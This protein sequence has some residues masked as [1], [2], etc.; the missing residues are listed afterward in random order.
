ML[1]VEKPNIFENGKNQE[2]V[3]CKRGKNNG[4]YD[5][6]PPTFYPLN[7]NLY[8]NPSPNPYP[9][10]YP[11]AYPNSYNNPYPNS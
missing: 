5:F 10:G 8:P 11:N 6:L 9:N 2:E 4:V 3:W 1:K 7:P